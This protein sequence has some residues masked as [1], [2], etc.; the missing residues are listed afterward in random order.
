[1]F[2]AGN[3]EVNATEQAA[4]AVPPAIGVTTTGLQ[5]FTPAFMKLTL[6]PTGTPAEDAPGGVI[7][8]DRVTT[9]LTT[10]VVGKL[11]ATLMSGVFFDTT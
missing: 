9:W 4:V 6:P 8:A 3:A 10:A 1:M 7:V 2:V 11:E 5:T